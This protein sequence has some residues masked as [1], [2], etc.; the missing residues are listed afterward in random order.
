MDEQT[1]LAVMM[2]GIEREAQW[3]SVLLVEAVVARLRYRDWRFSVRRGAFPTLN[4]TMSL[5]DS[6]TGRLT[7]LTHS[8]PIPLREFVDERGARRWLLERVFDIE[9]HEAMEHFL[10][11]GAAPF[12]PEHE[13]GRNPYAVVERAEP[14]AVD[15]P[16]RR[17][18]LLTPWWRDSRLSP[19][20]A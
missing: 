3:Q 17:D 14:V 1:A 6:R 12:F 5:P 10:I 7:T 4:V 18:D 9:K 2:D 19:Y 15:A 8:T 16:A 20:K 13:P 11:D